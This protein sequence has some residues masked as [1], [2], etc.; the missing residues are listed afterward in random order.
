[1]RQVMKHEFLLLNEEGGQ[2]S[3]EHPMEFDQRDKKKLK[4]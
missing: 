1:M 4:S 2:L 3:S